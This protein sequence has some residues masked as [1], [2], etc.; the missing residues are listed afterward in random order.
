MS[1]GNSLFISSVQGVSQVVGGASLLLIETGTSVPEVVLICREIN[2]I[3]NAM[4][5]RIR[6]VPTGTILKIVAM[7]IR[8]FIVDSGVIFGLCF[9]VLR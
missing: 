1:N 2:A 7:T 9:L 5:I 8:M 6:L 4:T 3:G